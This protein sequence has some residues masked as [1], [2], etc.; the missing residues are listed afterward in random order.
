MGVILDDDVADPGSPP[1]PVLSLG[2]L[3]TVATTAV[4]GLDVALSRTGWTT[5]SYTDGG[6]LDC[7]VVKTS[8]QLAF[9]ERLVT[10]RDAVD[11]ILDDV[12]GDEHDIDVA[13]EDGIAYR[14]GTTTRR[15]AMAW[16]MAV[17]AVWDAEGIE[18][19]IVKP[20]EVKLLATGRGNAKK[21]EVQAAA[22]ERWGP[23]MDD[24][25]VADAAWVAEHARLRMRD[26]YPEDS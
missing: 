10:I 25:D 13:I 8:P 7:G 14:S 9:L 26:L 12:R 21:N 3:I 11:E 6:L 22:V 19:H 1:T 17:I 23:R 4:L 16:A 20:T 5:L 24:S 2:T 15:L 18:P